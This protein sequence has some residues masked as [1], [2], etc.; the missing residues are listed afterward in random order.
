MRRITAAM[1]VFACLAS[2]SIGGAFTPIVTS[3][4]V[5]LDVERGWIAEGIVSDFGS[6]RCAD[7]TNYVE[8]ELQYHVDGERIEESF[9][10]DTTN[11]PDFI[12]SMK[13]GEWVRLQITGPPRDIGPF[14]LVIDCFVNETTH[15]GN[16]GITFATAIQEFSD[17]VPGAFYDEPS[18]WARVNFVTTGTSPSTFSP[19][20]RVTRWQMS[21]FLQRLAELFGTDA[22]AWSAIADFTDTQSIEAYKQTSIGWLADTGITTGVGGGRFDPN[23]EVTRWQMA[24]FLRRFAEYIGLDTSAATADT[25]DDTSN[26]SADKRE[27]IGWLAA[28]GVTTGVGQNRFDP[29]GLVS[30]GQMVTFLQRLH[31]YLLE[32]G[33]DD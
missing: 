5:D 12:A 19:G 21:L 16:A 24:L 7:V 15:V 33:F 23:G 22:L 2:A 3:I 20:D 25:F 1:V 26:L 29:N 28:S 6:M 4:G 17:V 27:A 14:K 13:A 8:F 18:L 11:A 31:T 30:R 9:T 32:Q 10:Y